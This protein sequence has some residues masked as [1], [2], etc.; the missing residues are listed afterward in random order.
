[1][2]NSVDQ[3]PVSGKARKTIVDIARIAGVNPSTVSRALSG[4]TAVTED[5]RDRIL[6]IARDVGYVANHNASRLRSQRAG[7]ILVIVPNIAAFS[8]PEVILG[9]EEGLAEHNVGV[10]VGSTKGNKDR[11]LLLAR[12]L[13]T[14]AADGLILMSGNLPAELSAPQYRHRIVAI[15]RPI[16]TEDVLFI[17]ID[18]HAAAVEAT[19][20]FLSQG[21]ESILHVGGPSDSPIFSARAQG[22]AQAMTDAGLERNIEIFVLPSFNIEA[23]RKA[24]RQLLAEGRAPNAILCASDE[25]AFGAIQVAREHRIRVPEDIAFIGFDDH[26]VSEAFFPPLTTV[27]VP[28]RDLGFTGAQMLLQSISGGH[29]ISENKI[30]PYQLRIRSSCGATA[31]E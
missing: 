5:T 26:P 11:E 4:S 3:L 23:G 15:S 31:S 30:L 6:S 28:R 19:R 12:Q 10:V 13:M 14:G 16:L 25:I 7:Q 27:A 18:N 20:H 21:R 9:I 22:Y 1:M 17:G 8:H 29:Q 2:A 24:M